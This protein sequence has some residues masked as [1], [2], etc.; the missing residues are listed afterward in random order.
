M[1]AIRLHGRPIRVRVARHLSEL[2]ARGAA[3][4]GDVTPIHPDFVYREYIVL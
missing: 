3:Y 4:L 2:R 1:Q